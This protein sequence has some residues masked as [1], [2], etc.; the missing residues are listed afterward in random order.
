[1]P[2][3]LEDYQF[4]DKDETKG[5]RGKFDPYRAV[6]YTHLDVYKRQDLPMLGFTPVTEGNRIDSQY[7]GFTTWAKSMGNDC[8]DWYKK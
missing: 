1:M 3:L 7:P 8:K 5:N 4:K 2:E 6:S